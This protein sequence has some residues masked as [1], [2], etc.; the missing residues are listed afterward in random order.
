MLDLASKAIF[1]T[2]SHSR[3]L[4]K[5]ASHY[6]VRG[7]RGVARR[8]VAGE[9]VEDAIETVRRLEA[10]GLHH[11]LDHLGES[12]S[13]LAETEACT[14]EY[15]SLI[16]DVAASGV[17]R[18]ISLKLTQ[19]GLDVDRAMCVDNLRRILAAGDQR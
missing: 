8:F 16:R 7:R 11:T 9:T 6:G 1:Q 5:L 2:L 14:Q 15:L 4:K 19:L 17:E 12:V 18:N 13:T 3:T 10:Q